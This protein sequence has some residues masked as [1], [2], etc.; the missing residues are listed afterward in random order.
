VFKPGLTTINQN[1]HSIGIKSIEYL[2]AM[3]EN[4]AY[5]P[6]VITEPSNLVIRQTTAPVNG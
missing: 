5:T 3:I 1:I 4:P 6:P 2:I